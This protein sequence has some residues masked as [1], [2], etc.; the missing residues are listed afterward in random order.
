MNLEFETYEYAIG[1]KMV[2]GITEMSESYRML[3][4]NN[5]R[6]AIESVKLELMQQT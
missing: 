3:M 1:G 4:E 2:K 6:A 5:D